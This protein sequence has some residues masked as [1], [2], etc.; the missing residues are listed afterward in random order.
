MKAARIHKP[1]EMLRIEEIEKPKLE[2]DTAVVKVK[3]AG[4]CATELDFLEGIFP[5][6]PDPLVLGHEIAGLIDEIDPEAGSGF[7]KGDRVAIHNVMNCGK[8]YHCRNGMENACP[9]RKG[10]IGFTHNGG[11][12]EYVQ[13]PVASLVALPEQVSFEE[14]AVLACSGMSAV[15]STRVA[16]TT[17]GDTVVVNGIGGVGIMC[18]QVAKIFGAWVIGVADSVEKVE[19]AKKV[20]ADEALVIS[21]YGK[22]GD[23]VRK[24]TDGRGVDVYYELVGTTATLKAGIDCLALGGRLLII[25]Y[26]KEQNLDFYPVDLLV[27]EGKV[28]TSV[29]GCKRDLELV[30]RFASQKR[31]NPIIEN[32]MPLARINDALQLIIDRKV[33]GR[34]VI[35]FD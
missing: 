4:V 12:E 26:Q 23:E 34:S 5:F 19:L 32:R 10:Q 9:N 20:G 31:A 22:L 13:I 21:D 28:V 6:G 35:V 3:A 14:G 30:L 33:K 8:C 17:A 24:L 11:F 15:H 1:G 27:K 29:A 2:K 18:I 25:G 7:K 16:G